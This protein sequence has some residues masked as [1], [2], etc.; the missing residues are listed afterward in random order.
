MELGV[1]L[2]ASPTA[3]RTATMGLEWPIESVL[4]LHQQTVGTSVKVP[5]ALLNNATNRT[6][7]AVPTF[8]QT[9]QAVSLLVFSYVDGSW[10]SWTPWSR[11]DKS[12]GLGIRKRKRECNSPPPNQYGSPC[13]GDRVEEIPCSVADCP[14]GCLTVVRSVPVTDKLSFLRRP[15]V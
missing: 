15:L 8:H 4:H 14:I 3:T 7:H 9:P 1:H 12:C 5:T 6:V 11:C 13:P 2:I 10:G